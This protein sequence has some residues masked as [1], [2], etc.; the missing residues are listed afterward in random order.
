[1]FETESADR[2]RRHLAQL[3]ING[4]LNPARQAFRQSAAYDKLKP[5]KKTYG[6]T[7]VFN[8]QTGKFT[9]A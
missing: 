6:D 5:H 2:E 4:N 3:G 9:E 8:T 1:M 7:M